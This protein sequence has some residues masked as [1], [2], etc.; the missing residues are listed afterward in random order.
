MKNLLICAIIALG[1]ASCATPEVKYA[2]KE[3]LEITKTASAKSPEKA[4]A[5]SKRWLSSFSDKTEIDAEKYASGKIS[6]MCTLK[7]GFGMDVSVMATFLLEVDAS[8][9]DAVV[10][11]RALY[12]EAGLI[13]TGVHKSEFGESQASMA[14]VCA[15]KLAMSLISE[16]ESK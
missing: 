6:S 13:G 7:N 12:F 10:K 2:T 11:A 8:N 4:F 5:K 16:I 1:A 9:K 15:E 3:Q 14:K